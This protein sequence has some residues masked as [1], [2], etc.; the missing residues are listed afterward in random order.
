MQSIVVGTDG[1][2][3]AE[4]AVRRTVELVKGSEVTV[5]VVAAYH[6]AG[7]EGEPLVGTARRA[8]VDLRETAESV[9]SR[10][11]SELSA[12]GVAVETD[13]REGDPAQVILDVAEEQ[14]ADLIVVGARGATGLQRFLVGGVASKLVHH[15]ACSVM[16]VRERA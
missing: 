2:A 9:L 14:G 13:A 12:A 3:N 4:A 5:H 15:A 7:S 16:I 11:A 6:D 1:S 8:R 10:A